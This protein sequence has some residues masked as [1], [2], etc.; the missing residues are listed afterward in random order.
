MRRFEVRAQLR[1]NFRQNPNPKMFPNSPDA[2]PALAEFI[3]AQIRRDGPV[4]FAWFMEQALFHPTLGYY[5]SGRAEIGRGG[6]YFTSVSAGPLFGHLLGGQFAQIWDLLGQPDNFAIVEQGAHRGDFARDVLET[7]RENY[8]T[9]F[10]AVRYQIVEPFAVL[11]ARQTETLAAFHDKV[12]WTD[13]L[14]TLAPFRGLH[15][16]NELLD[17]LPMHLLKWTGTE[18]LE[19]FVESENEAFVLVDRP[20]SAP[21]LA[22]RV[23]RIPLPLPAGYETEVNLA[24]AQWLET[25]APKLL[26]GFVLAA[27]Y[28]FARDEFY[29]S[30]RTAGTLRSYARH[31]L[32]PSSLAHPGHADITAHVDWTA[33]AEIAEARGLRVAGFTDQHHFITGLLA[34]AIG[35]ELGESNDPKTKRALQTLIHPG[36]LGMKFQF[37]VLA[38]NIPPSATISGLQFARAPQPALGY[39]VGE[40]R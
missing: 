38:K 13:S 20:L 24:A 16:S 3:R 30:H 12:C 33:L 7:L 21:K 40:G 1:C 26:E 4:T 8:P 15:F 39:G 9:C 29:A 31:Q 18:W 17:A 37:L 34:S 28:G 32:L 2:D 5:S 27:D 25:L 36:F 10:A 23:R 35:R 6:D 14:E 22:E 11:R 19:R